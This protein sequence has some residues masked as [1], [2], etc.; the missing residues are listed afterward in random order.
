MT[1]SRRWRVIVA[2]SSTWFAFTAVASPL[3]INAATPAQLETLPGIGP[4]K[5]LAIVDFRQRH[6]PF[7]SL[8][9]LDQVP[10]IGPATLVS[11]RGLVT[12]GPGQTSIEPVVPP[13]ATDV[14][15]ID[16]NSATALDLQALPG[17]GPTKAEAIVSDR[18]R[19]GPYS[20]CADLVRVPGLGPATVESVAD[21]CAAT[22]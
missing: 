11:L 13:P 12:T 17:I 22:E 6:G 18:A 1:S 14:R 7:E 15:R 3:D 5:A 16:I 9:G 4:A 10:G 20:S 19:N 21:R 2:V 8:E